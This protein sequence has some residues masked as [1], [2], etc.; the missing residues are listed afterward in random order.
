MKTTSK[1]PVI[2]LIGVEKLYEMDG[3]GVSALLNI[4][5]SIYSGEYVSIVGPSG[6]GKSTLMHI[7]GLL[8]TPSGGKILLE[9]K[10]VSKL[11]EKELAG[12]RNRHIGFVFQQFNLLAKTFSW[13]NVSLPLIY[14]GVSRIERYRRSVA[15]LA[16]VGLDDKLVN[17]PNQLSGGQQQRVA[18]ARALINNP[19]IILADEPTGNLDTASGN[20]I[21]DLF[22]RLNEEGKT[23]V[24]VTHEKDIAKRARRAIHIVDGRIVN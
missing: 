6:S 16:Q 2:Q 14:S 11:S 13:Q 17:R 3:T 4:N 21:M 20:T 18:I 5:V 15:A 24:L 19:M 10:D 9:G 23:I 7:L 1:T 22:D 8:D 12:L